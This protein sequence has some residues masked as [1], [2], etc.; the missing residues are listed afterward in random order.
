MARHAIHWR[1]LL[2]MATDAESHCVIHC[3]LGHGRLGHITVAG[4]AVYPSANVGRMI[5]FHMRGGFKAIDALPRNVFSTR[6]I[7]CQ[8]FDFRL[9]RGDYL[10]ARH[11]EIDAGY[12][13][14]RSLIHSYMAIDALQ[15]IR[16]MHLV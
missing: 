15:T 5:E 16:K 12:P 7:R 14:I 1:L 3:A 6:L 8:F 9:V 10:V 13:R 4:G 11:A 2:L